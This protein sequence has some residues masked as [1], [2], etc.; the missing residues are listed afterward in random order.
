[1][2]AEIKLTN[3]EL[4]NELK[5]RIN[6]HDFCLRVKGFKMSEKDTGNWILVALE[7]DTD[8]EELEIYDE[9][10]DEKE[11]TM[12]ELEK[13]TVDRVHERIMKELFLSSNKCWKCGELF[14]DNPTWKLTMVGWTGQ[15]MVCLCLKC[16]DLV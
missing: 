15:K 2:N 9:R 3:Q 8:R 16:K 7:G 14:I 11:K 1:M 12:A 10:K 4:I 6:R 13:E 5:K